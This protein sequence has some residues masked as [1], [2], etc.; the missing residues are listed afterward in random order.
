MLDTATM[1]LNHLTVLDHGY[2]G[3]DGMVYGGSFHPSFLIEGDVD[4]V[5]KVVVDFSTVKKMI[6]AHIDDN[7]TGFDHK[8]WIMTG[9]SNCD[10]SITDDTIHIESEF[11]ILDLPLN[12]VKIFDCPSHSTYDVGQA[13][14]EYVEVQMQ[15]THPGIRAVCYNSTTP[16]VIND[17]LVSMFTYVHG[18]KDSTSWGCQNNSHGHLSFVQVIGSPISSN[19]EELAKVEQ[20]IALDLDETVFI[21]IENI[22]YESSDTVTIEYT[23]EERGTFKAQYNLSTG[24]KTV[25][26]DTETTIE[27]LIE[28][29]AD[30][31]ADELASC[32]A[33]AI[34]VSEGLPKGA[35]KKLL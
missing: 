5:E 26:L 14:E 8:L 29:V 35:Y 6:K 25:V 4:P 12:A 27:Y 33:T 15:E 18:L 11:V 19:A 23:T 30:V 20:A 2:I 1:H 13:L 21:N 34:M 3:N 9:Y 32:G 31:Y 10:Y 17:D 16:H 24:I 28:Y 22:V 7:Q